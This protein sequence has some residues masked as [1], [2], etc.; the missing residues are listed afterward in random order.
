MGGV[1]KI[2]MMIVIENNYINVSESLDQKLFVM[3]VLMSI[4]GSAVS[5]A[6]AVCRKAAIA[7]RS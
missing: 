3:L 4:M 1:H 7:L 6:K 5:V 2:Y